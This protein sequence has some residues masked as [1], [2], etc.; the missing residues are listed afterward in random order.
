MSLHSSR[1]RDLVT[2]VGLSIASF[3]PKDCDLLICR[4]KGVN[5]RKKYPKIKTPSYCIHYS[6]N[7]NQEIFKLFLK[8]LKLPSVDLYSGVGAG[9]SSMKC[10]FTFS[11]TFWGHRLIVS[12]KNVPLL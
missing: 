3:K 8:F 7:L 4:R 9:T 10:R 12:F 1:C 2:L 6:D 11:A 5:E